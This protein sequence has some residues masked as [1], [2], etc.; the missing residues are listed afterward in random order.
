MWNTVFNSDNPFWNA[1]G[2]VFDLFVLNCLLLLCSIPIVTIGPALTAFFYVLIGL[3]RGES[4]YVS[5]DFFK[6]FK[7]NLKQG[8]LLGLPLTLVGVFLAVDI[9][10]CRNSGTG[11]YT[12]FLFFFAVIFL[13]WA[14]ITLYAFPILAKFE[15][16]NGEILLWAFVLSI[17]NW[18]RTLIM[19]FAVAAAIFMISIIPGLIFIAPGLVGDVQGNMMAGILKPYLPKLYGEND[20]EPLSFMQEEAEGDDDEMGNDTTVRASAENTAE[21]AGENTGNSAKTPEAAAAEITETEAAV[22]AVDDDAC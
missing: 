3:A 17:R 9:L 15:K 16:K 1:M 11:I 5:R 4:G 19:L 12:F 18:W 14:F 21:P 6:S 13:L 2:R 8:I 22:K 7:A 10:M 20:Y